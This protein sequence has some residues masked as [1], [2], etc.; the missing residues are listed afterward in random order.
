M[1]TNYLFCIVLILSIVVLGCTQG[2]TVV[3]GNTIPSD[4]KSMEADKGMKEGSTEDKEKDTAMMD[5]GFEM[6]DGKMAMINGKTKAMSPME[7]E[8][9]LEDGTIIRTNGQIIRTN[10]TTFTLKEGESIWMDGSFTKAGEMM[11]RE[12]TENMANSKDI[13]ASEFKGKVLAGSKTQYIEFNKGDFNEA[14]KENKTILLNFY[15]NWCPMCKAE[16]SEVFAA[17]GQM[18]NGNVVGFRVNFKDSDTDSDEEA[19]AE[20]YQIV[21]QHTKVIIKDSKQILKAPDSWDN[22]K[23]LDE[24]AKVQ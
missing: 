13:M 22:Q 3:P 5:E 1:K 4:K 19:M 12:S 24:I 15:A 6:K 21:Y 2:S 8:T 17:F 16:Q 7:K 11:E 18:H 10:G 23:Y 14:L 20:K 9:E